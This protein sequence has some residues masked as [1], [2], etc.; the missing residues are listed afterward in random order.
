MIFPETYAKNAKVSSITALVPAARP[1][2]PSVIF[3]PLETA[4]T[5]KITTGMKTI[6]D[7]F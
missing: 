5:M 6:Q 4:V 7:H 2:I 3:A 1:S